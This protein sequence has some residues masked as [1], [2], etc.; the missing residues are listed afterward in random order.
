V[1]RGR[2]GPVAVALRDGRR[3]PV[4]HSYAADLR[5]Q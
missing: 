5:V 1:R 3:L 4:S 2:K